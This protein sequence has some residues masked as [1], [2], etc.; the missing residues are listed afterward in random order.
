MCRC[1]GDR[2]QNSQP[3]LNIN[4]IERADIVSDILCCIFAVCIWFKKADGHLIR[5]GILPG[6]FLFAVNIVFDLMMFLWGPM[7]ITFS[8]YM[9]DIGFTYLIYPI[10]TIGFGVFLN[11]YRKG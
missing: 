5:E 10:I 3:A 11:Q 4:R 6:S 1:H 7:Q 8:A 9:N 2:K